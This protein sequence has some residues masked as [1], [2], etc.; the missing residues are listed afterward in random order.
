MPNVATSSSKEFISA[1]FMWPEALV[2]INHD[3]H[4]TS[5]VLHTTAT[6]WKDLPFCWLSNSYSTS[7]LPH[8]TWLLCVLLMIFAKNVLHYEVCNMWNKMSKQND[9]IN[10]YHISLHTENHIKILLIT[11]AQNFHTQKMHII[12]YSM[13]INW[14]NSRIIGDNFDPPQRLL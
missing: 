1:N 3:S 5:S 4:W 12:T 14:M 11:Y 2:N 13:C 7:Q 9:W 8:F 6:W 10:S